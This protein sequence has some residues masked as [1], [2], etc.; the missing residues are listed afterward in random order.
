MDQQVVTPQEPSSSTLLGNDFAD[1]TTTA[2]EML[3][4]FDDEWTFPKS[5]AYETEHSL[6]NKYGMPTSSKAYPM[7]DM[8]TPTISYAMA[9]A[10]RDAAHEMDQYIN[11]SSLDVDIAPSGMGIF[12][13]SPERHVFEYNLP[14]ASSTPAGPTPT[15]TRGKKRQLEGLGVGESPMGGMRILSLIHI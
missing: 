10:D 6:A 3:H 11:H 14:S 9:N 13:P 8:H 5:Y 7:P 12:D 1:I 4:T 2:P 15:P